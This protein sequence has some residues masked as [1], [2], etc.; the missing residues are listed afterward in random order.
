MSS[1]DDTKE[2]MSEV[3][4]LVVFSLPKVMPYAQRKK[5]EAPMQAIVRNQAK[6]TH[7]L[8]D[9]VRVRYEKGASTFYPAFA[10]CDVLTHK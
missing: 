4:H 1:T 8:R 2:T 5:M 6:K 7:H 3:S 9:V 10:Y